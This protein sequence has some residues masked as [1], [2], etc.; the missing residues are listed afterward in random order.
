LD[1]QH[2]LST[3][4]PKLDTALGGGLPLGSL[5]LLE[6]DGGCAGHAAALASLFS[7]EGL[8]WGHGLIVG[9]ADGRYDGASFVEALPLN[10]SRDSADLAALAAGG[11]GGGAPEVEADGGGGGGA[12]AEGAAGLV[13]AWQYKKYLAVEEG[14]GG[15][16]GGCGGGGGGG[17]C[18]GG[19]VD[20]KYCHTFDLSRRVPPARRAA[21]RITALPW[22]LPG[23]LA[24]APPPLQ[25][26]KV[27]ELLLRAQAQL[28]RGGGGEGGVDVLGALGAALGARGVG[29][30]GDAYDAVA[31]EVE[32]ALAAGGGGGGG[33]APQRVVL[34]GVGGPL[35]PGCT[36]SDAPAAAALPGPAGLPAPDAFSA[37]LPLLRALRRLRGAV[38]GAAGGAVALV[39]AATWAMPL[40]AAEAARRL[41]DVVVK[42]HGFGDPAY[43]LLTAGPRGAG[44][45]G[46]SGARG[47]G[48]AAPARAAAPFKDF[49][50]LL[51]LRRLPTWGA[52]APP[53]V[54]QSLTL[55]FKRDAKKF[56][57]EPPHTPPEDA[58]PPPPP[59]PPPTTTTGAAAAARQPGLACASG[60]GLDF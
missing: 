7:A 14:G 41:A 10:V 48:L 34:L 2:I 52:A 20:P 16:G 56:T 51:L 38:R 22:R 8:A 26:A 45:E 46:A 6:E 24:G 23:P 29:C 18:G 31:E 32:G 60:G 49:T 5:V 21:C 11:G 54:P 9:G 53:A 58:A 44:P 17:G 3:G 30:V 28:A 42:V 37:H 13:N 1:G 12:I 43:G 39:T 40:A 47:E 15:G 57:L 36:G 55:L 59:P 25:R 35:W 27:T 4:H 19:G 33:G 50:G